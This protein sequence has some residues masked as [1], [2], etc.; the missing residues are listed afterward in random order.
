MKIG[1]MQLIGYFEKNKLK[2]Q[3]STFTLCEYLSRIQNKLD[4]DCEPFRK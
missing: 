4:N 3:I 1:H 2:T